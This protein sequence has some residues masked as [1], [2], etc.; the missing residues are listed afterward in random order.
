M[1]DDEIKRMFDQKEQELR[2]AHADFLKY[3]QNPAEQKKP[4]LRLH[5]DP[6]IEAR[7]AEFKK[8]HDIQKNEFLRKKREEKLKIIANQTGEFPNFREYFKS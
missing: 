4:D 8:V 6:E 2:K 5:T 3:K 1:D 7:V